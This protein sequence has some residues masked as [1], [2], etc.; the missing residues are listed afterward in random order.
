MAGTVALFVMGFGFRGEGR[1]NRIE[2]AI[3]LLTFIAYSAYLVVS[4]I[5]A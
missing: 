1:I 4:V 3:L 5:P 2:G